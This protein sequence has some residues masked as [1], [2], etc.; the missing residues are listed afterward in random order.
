MQ[1]LDARARDILVNRWTG[2]AKATLHDL[3]DKY[4]VV[5]RAHP[6]DRGQRDQETARFDG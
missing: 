1:T 4:G 2:E 5:G 3:A 6:A